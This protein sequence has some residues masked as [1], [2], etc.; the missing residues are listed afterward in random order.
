MAPLLKTAMPAI[1]NVAVQ[2]ELPSLP[3]FIDEQQFPGG[4]MQRFENLGSGVVT[5]PDKGY[6]V[7]SSHVV[8][9]SSLIMVTLNDGRRV[10]AS[11]VGADPETDIAVLQI[12]AENLQS[13]PL[14]NSSA[15]EVGDFVVAIGNPFGLNSLGSKQTAT[16]GIISALQRTDLNIE[17]LE[18]FIQT[19]AAI[20]PG[21]SGGALVNM[22]GELI[23][24]NTAII[25]PFAGN[26]GVGLA[27]PIDMVKQV[28]DQLIEYG[29]IE[30]GLLGI[31][32]Q[33]LSPE[34]AE[35]FDETGTKGALVS[36]VN[37]GSPAEKA[38]MQAGD[39]IQEISDVPI[40]Y[41]SQ[42]KNT[43][44]LLRTGTELNI[45]VLRDGK[46]VTMKTIITDAQR[47]EEALQ[48]QNPF[49]FGLALRD[50]VQ[51]SPMHGLVEGV[52]VVGATENNEGWRAGL[53]P[54]DVI[55]AA[56]QEKVTD[57]QQLQS[58]TAK[59][60]DMLLLH[61]LRGVGS[62]YVVVKQS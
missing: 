58:A 15:L 46:T 24:I 13:L 54:G 44:G 28:M 25:A 29:S 32:V 23:G 51:E 16:F 50:F 62:L 35:A 56:N 37:P 59:N 39:I 48:A 12:E 33:Q 6:I 3:D 5:D 17:G 22:R 41:A 45:K 1:V 9:N 52:Q 27:V 34:V 14:G 38:G 57:L 55:I 61:I 60:K 53:R 8:T 20:N 30:R 18:N 26:V 31:F 36:Q 19:D 11:M 21:S 2:G 7:T 10:K 47:H 4:G 49:L 43:V 42:V 40:T